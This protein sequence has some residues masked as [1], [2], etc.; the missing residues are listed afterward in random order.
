M[1]SKD[2]KYNNK[3]KEKKIILW[4]VKSFPAVEINKREEEINNPEIKEKTKENRVP[5]T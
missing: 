5:V 1:K 2:K 4:E 3:D